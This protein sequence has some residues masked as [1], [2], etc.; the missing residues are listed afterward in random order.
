MTHK[1]GVYCRK[2]G[3]NTVDIWEENRSLYFPYG[4]NGW[5]PYG[6]LFHTAA[7]T[8]HDVPQNGISD[9][10]LTIF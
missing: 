3:T 8:K 2:V 5:H 4:R 6:H 7:Y 10:I 9:T 1:Y